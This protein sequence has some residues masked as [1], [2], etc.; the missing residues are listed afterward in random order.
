MWPHNEGLKEKHAEETKSVGADGFNEEE[1][2]K[3]LTFGIFPFF[4]LSL[5]LSLSR[6]PTV[7]GRAGASCRAPANVASAKTQP[8]L[9]PNGTTTPRIGWHAA[10][11]TD[12]MGFGR[13]A[14]PIWLD[15]I[16]ASPADV[17][18]GRPKREEA[19]R[20]SRRGNE[21]REKKRLVWA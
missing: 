8:R 18:L 3:G 15:L 14:P 11:G 20:E 7:R 10:R 17:A 2:R 12:P 19:E 6:R 21:K 16:D 4:S 1:K 13:V 9:A 5:S